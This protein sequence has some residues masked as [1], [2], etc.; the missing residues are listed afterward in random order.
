MPDSTITCPHCHRPFE[1][2]KVMSEGIEASL[3][4]DLEAETA[5]RNAE[6]DARKKQVEAQA[7]AV[8]QAKEQVDHLVAEKLSAER[9][10]VKSNAEKA[11]KEAADLEI[12]AL[13]TRLKESSDRLTAAHERESQLA[14][15]E[16][17]LEDRQRELERTVQERLRSERT[18]MQEQARTEAEE[19]SKL[20]MNE[21]SS[22]LEGKKRKL[23]EAERAELELRQSKAA[24]EDERRRFDLDKQRAI[25]DAKSALREQAQRDAEETFR[26]AVADKEKV[27]TDMKAKIDDLQRKSQQGSQQLQGEVLELDFEASLREAFPKDTIEPVAKG[28]SGADVLQRVIGP[29]HTAVGAILWETKRTKAWSDAWLDKLRADKQEAKAEL[30]AIVSEALPKGINGFGLI[31]GVWV[32]SP[33]LAIALANALRFALVEVSGVRLASEGRHTKV[34]LLYEYLVGNDFRNR[35][36]TS[37]RAVQDMAEDLETERRAITKMWK[38]RE[39]QIKKVSDNIA[40]MYGDMQGIV[41]KSLPEIDGMDLKLLAASESDEE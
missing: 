5:R 29:R 7:T 11:A 28:A 38:K 2:T 27:I 36:E 40:G 41:G 20:R 14:A 21:L 37:V 26:L 1:L 34:E 8:V 25:D 23:V 10:Q 24:L 15:R 18:A 35:V 16:R 9:A 30:C 4:A 39:K 32:C 19:Q 22:E 33:I 6:I 3:R 31:D 17:G 13:E 12:R